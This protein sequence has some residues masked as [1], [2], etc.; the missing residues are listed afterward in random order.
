ME[1]SAASWKLCRLMNTDPFQGHSC[2]V[3]SEEPPFK[4]GPDSKRTDYE[5][6]AKVTNL[7]GDTRCRVLSSALRGSGASTYC[8][9]DQISD[10]D[11]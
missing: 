3:L 1:Y 11:C 6:P 4:S 2:E 5:F 10:N 8:F 9:V 7:T